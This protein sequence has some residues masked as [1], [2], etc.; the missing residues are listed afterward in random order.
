MRKP[1]LILL[2][3]ALALPLGASNKKKNKFI[4]NK[5]P[6][7]WVELARVADIKP[8]QPCGNWAWAANM[9]SLLRRQKIELDQSYWIM[10]LYG[11]MR[12]EPNILAFEDLKR[13]IDGE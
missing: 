7:Q 11:G 6:D 4:M 8:E 13:R 12:C 9:E 2:V 5:N 1:L 10:K 3:V